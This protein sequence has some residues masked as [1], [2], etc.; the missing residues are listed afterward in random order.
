MITA[1]YPLARL[2]LAM[3]ETEVRAVVSNAT[4]SSSCMFITIV[5][6][7]ATGSPRG[8]SDI[9]RNLSRSWSVVILIVPPRLKRTSVSTPIVAKHAFKMYTSTFNR[10]FAFKNFWNP[11]YLFHPFSPPYHLPIS[12]DPLSVLRYVRRN[13]DY[14]KLPIADSTTTQKIEK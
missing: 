10:R 14:K 5:P 2:S 3:V 7:L 6:R 8:L 11:S 9:K 1:S 12:Y 4:R 13:K